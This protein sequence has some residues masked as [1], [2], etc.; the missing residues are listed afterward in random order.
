MLLNQ[1]DDDTDG[2]G[3]PLLLLCDRI[4][5]RSNKLFPL[6]L[7]VQVDSLAIEGD[8]DSRLVVNRYRVPM[9]QVGQMG[10]GR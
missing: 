8:T 5:A 4:R 7:N 9:V 3:D 10:Y 2:A 6:A 1:E